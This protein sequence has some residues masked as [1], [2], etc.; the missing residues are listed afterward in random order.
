MQSI[1]GVRSGA[2][3]DRGMKEL[4]HVTILMSILSSEKSLSK[5][6]REQ[7][8]AFESQLL[9]CLTNVVA[10]AKLCPIRGDCADAVEPEWRSTCRNVEYLAG[11]KDVPE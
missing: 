5:E 9:T 1:D 8:L 10:C 2:L 7:C 11:G 6:L 4:E 3:I